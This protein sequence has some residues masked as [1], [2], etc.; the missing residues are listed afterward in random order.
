MT[1][2]SKNENNKSKSIAEQ[3]KD[4]RS[5]IVTRHY[6]NFKWQSFFTIPTVE[7]NNQKIVLSFNR[8]QDFI[9]E[10]C[11]DDEQLLQLHEQLC[12]AYIHL[13]DNKAR[14]QLNTIVE[15]LKV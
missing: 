9:M 5:E 2:S 6:M 3:N 12:I 1:D 13:F 10:L 7:I 14:K 8:G 11:F 15:N 4:F